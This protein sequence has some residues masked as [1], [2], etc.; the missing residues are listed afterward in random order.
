MNEKQTGSGLA[1][2]ALAAALAAPGATAA[3]PAPDPVAVVEKMFA[4]WHE[5]D[6]ERVYGLFHEDGV[7][8][9]MMMEP[10]VGRAAIRARLE[11]L[12]AGIERIDLEVRRIGVVDGAVVVE[13]VDDFVF[14]G[15]A[16]R[17]PVV[18]VLEVEDGRIKV[19]REYYDHAQLRAAMGLAAAE[20][21]STPPG[22]P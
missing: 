3:E 14:R 18:G 15:H 8:H 11:P 17:V 2:L 5:R 16:G 6:W 7:L 20:D 13:R 9:S 10:I 12:L 4:A 1:A 21:H 19:W 22:A